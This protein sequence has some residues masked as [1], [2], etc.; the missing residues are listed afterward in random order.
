MALARTALTLAPLVLK[1][2]GGRSSKRT[3]S[4]GAVIAL[5]VLS[6]VFLLAAGFIAI[7][8]RF[9]WDIS[10]L[11]LGATTLLIAAVLYVSTHKRP[12]KPEP[13][14][15]NKPADPLA[16]IIPENLQDDPR[17]EA[18]MERIQTHPMEA[19]AAAAGLGLVLSGAIFGD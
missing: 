7:G 18:L 19:A 9:G 17:L 16:Q 6:V 12:I 2:V 8:A 5:I 13:M 3:A 15:S 14:E 10:F 11:A 1:G 4:F